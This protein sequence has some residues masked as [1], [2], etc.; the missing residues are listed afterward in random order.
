VSEETTEESIEKS[1]EINDETNITESID[2]SKQIQI[3]DSIES[4][5]YI[6]LELENNSLKDERSQELFSEI[7]AILEKSNYAELVEE[8]K[9]TNRTIPSNLM[10]HIKKGLSLEKKPTDE[11]YD[12]TIELKGSILSRAEFIYK[13]KEDIKNLRY[14]TKDDLFWNGLSE[15]VDLRPLN[16]SQK[17]FDEGKYDIAGNVF[18]KLRKEIELKTYQD[19]ERKKESLQ[20]VLDCEKILENIEEEGFNDKV[21]KDLLKQTKD[22]FKSK[23]FYSIIDRI[24]DIDAP[25]WR[26]SKQLL[27]ASNSSSERPINEDYDTLTEFKQKLT[28][29]KE[30][31]EYIKV[32]IDELGNK[33]EKDKSIPELNTE[34]YSK[35]FD[36]VKKLFSDKEYD[37]AFEEAIQIEIDLEDSVLDLMIESYNIIKKLNSSNFTTLYLSDLLRSAYDSFAPFQSEALLKRYVDLE[38]ENKV[39]FVENVLIPIKKSMK[40]R[41][42]YSFIEFRSIVETVNE[43][44]YREEQIYRVDDTIK[45]LSKKIEDYNQKGIDVNVSEKKF[46]EAVSKFDSENYDDAESTLFEV[47]TK[48]ELAKARLTVLNV[49]S[50]EG[51]SFLQK[52]KYNL[53]PL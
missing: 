51:L 15:I 43:I 37:L 28:E 3:L 19:I 34:E 12:N 38:E 29:R 36:T 25:S 6:L 7:K 21:A 45:T 49:L 52:N 10:F 18:D 1:T 39:S 48:L 32:F 20:V 30:R 5:E 22:F 47:N 33:L 8:V 24:E 42:G 14:E 9:K 44:K 16:K 2:I 46:Q 35:R 41:E 17:L 50:V 27:K 4:S 31:L 53:I 23:D 26:D 11:D 13:L 40:K